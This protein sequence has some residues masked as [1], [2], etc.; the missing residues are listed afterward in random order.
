MKLKIIVLSLEWQDVCYFN[1]V[2]LENKHCILLKQATILLI[3]MNQVCIILTRWN[4]T[5]ILK[6]MLN[7]NSNFQEILPNVVLRSAY[8]EEPKPVGGNITK[9][10]FLPDSLHVPNWTSTWLSP[11]IPLREFP[12]PVLLTS[13]FRTRSGEWASLQC[14]W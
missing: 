8:N 14:P 7:Q 3:L 12:V 4:D 13:R 11:S 2:K 5:A 6:T 9:Q 10:D 1:Y